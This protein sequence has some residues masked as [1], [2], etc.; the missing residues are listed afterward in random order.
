MFGGDFGAFRT[1]NRSFFD[2]NNPI[3][4]EMKNLAELRKEYIHLRLGR[5]YLREIA[6]ENEEFHLPTAGEDRCKEI[7]AWSRILSQEEFLLAV[8][9]ELKKGQRA[10][11][12]IDN[13]LHEPGDKFVC[14]YSSN[15]EQL[16][17]ELEIIKADEFNNYIEFE[18]PAQGRTVFKS[19]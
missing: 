9:C 13:E 17:E 1:Q 8:N 10:R 18:V 4:K 12:I 15:Q 6:A 11:V 5:Q 14:I 7:I 16:G 2:R 19:A 3:Y